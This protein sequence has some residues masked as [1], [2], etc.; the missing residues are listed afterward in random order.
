MA[1]RKMTP[2]ERARFRQWE[3]ESEERL[4]KLRELVARGWEELA[5]KQRRAEAPPKKA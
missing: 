1:K 4:R 5:R 2:E 3:A